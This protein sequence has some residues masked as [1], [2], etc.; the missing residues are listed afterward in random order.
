MKGYLSGKYDENA[1]ETMYKEY[2]DKGVDLI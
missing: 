2:L 1:I